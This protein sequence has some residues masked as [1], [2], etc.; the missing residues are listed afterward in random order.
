MSEKLSDLSIVKLEDEDVEKIC[1]DNIANGISSLTGVTTMASTPSVPNNKNNVQFYSISTTVYVD[2]VAYK[3]FEIIAHG[4]GINDGSLCVDDQVDLLSKDTYTTT[5]MK[6]IA[7]WIS[8]VVSTFSLEWT[9]VDYI[10]STSSYFSNTTLTKRLRDEY[11]G[12]K[13]MD[14]AYV[15]KGD[16]SYS[17][18]LTTESVYVTNYLTAIWWDSAGDK[19]I[20][21]TGSKNGRFKSEKYAN[22]NKAANRYAN[23]YR[24][25]KYYKVGDISILYNGVVKDKIVLG[26]YKSLASVPGA[27]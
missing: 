6:K 13:T 2:D 18:V 16:S 1:N 7:S 12:T 4:T 24:T 23:G 26:T 8:S 9:A 15:A 21:Y 20:E 17:H 5:M 11:S 22:V 27:S 25:P 14:F 10:A 3:V 19:H